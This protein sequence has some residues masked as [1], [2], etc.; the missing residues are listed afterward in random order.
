MINMVA[1]GMGVAF[2][3]GP[4]S[5]R[6]LAE[7][8]SYLMIDDLDIELNLAAMWNADRESK[9]IED[10]VDLVIAHMGREQSK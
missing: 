7:G 10:F 2:F 1:E 8:V 6:R 5:A 3:N 4:M 9:A